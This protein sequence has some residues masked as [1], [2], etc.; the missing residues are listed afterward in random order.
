MSGS[1]ES[2]TDG[3]SSAAS[4]I[5]S[6]TSL[7]S[8]LRSSMDSESEAN[9]SVDFGGAEDGT[10]V[11]PEFKAKFDQVKATY[12]QTKNQYLSIQR[13]FFDQ[14]KDYGI[15]DAGASGMSDY[16]R[17]YQEALENL[18]VRRAESEARKQQLESE[19]QALKDHYTRVETEKQAKIDEFQKLREKT[20]QES[21]MQRTNKP[22]RQQ[23]LNSKEA[24]LT[25]K[26]NE[27]EKYRISFIS[28][29]N[30]NKA[31]QDESLNEK[32][33]EKNQET[34]KIQ[35][36]IETNCHK[37]THVKEK[38]AFVR[39]QKAELVIRQ[40]K[41]DDDYAESRS[42]LALAR[43][44]RDKVRDDNSNLKKS[45]GL[46]GMTD[47]LYDFEKRS[48]E[49][50]LMQDRV[51]ELKT[52]YNDLLAMQHEL[53]AKIAQRQPLDQSLLRMNR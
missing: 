10:D 36:K 21:I 30:K 28:A 1:Q 7:G 26:D 17:R 20:A 8:S 6:R 11:S 38:L 46:I 4:A 44:R 22:I 9:D 35:Q 29:K 42:K 49:L 27:L 33:A 25:Q 51:T 37:L 31:T 41:M 39:K 47:L 16:Q 2:D 32:K 43:I 53:E 23:D 19:L 12:L 34:V 14:F 13:K 24:A 3:G 50:E 18:D 15:E 52:R 45:S 5:G 48:N 40:K